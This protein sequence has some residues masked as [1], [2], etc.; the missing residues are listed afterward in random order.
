MAVSTGFRRS[1]R[2]FMHWGRAQY[3]RGYVSMWCELRR[4]SRRS[5][6]AVSISFRTVERRVCTSKAARALHGLIALH[7]RSRVCSR[8]YVL[9]SVY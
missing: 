1:P 8:V 2:Y 6:A 7:R 5:R 3:V 4:V 9:C